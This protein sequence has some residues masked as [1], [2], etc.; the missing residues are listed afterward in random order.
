[1]LVKSSTAGSA[2]NRSRAAFATARAMGC[3]EASSMAPA[4]RSTSSLS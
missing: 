3:S 1:M 2:P 4:R